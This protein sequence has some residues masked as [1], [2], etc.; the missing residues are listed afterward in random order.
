MNFAAAVKKKAN[1]CADLLQC[2]F[3]KTQSKKP[4]LGLF[5]PIALL[6]VNIGINFMAGGFCANALPILALITLFL[7][8]RFKR[9]GLIGSY[10]LLAIFLFCSFS[11]IPQNERIFQVGFF[12]S[13]ALTLFIFLLTNEGLQ[14]G[15]E[16]IEEELVRKREDFEKLQ[17]AFAS[18]QK[19]QEEKEREFEEELNRLKEQ[20]EQRKIDQI[21]TLKKNQLIQ[22]EIELLTSQ[23]EAFIQDARD[24]R[25][26]AF[27]ANKQLEEL[28]KSQL[29]QGLNSQ[30]KNI[31]ID[32]LMA[33]N[34]MLIN[35]KEQY[36]EKVDALS[37]KIAE[38]QKQFEQE[39]LYF[40]QQV[41]ASQQAILSLQALSQ[42]A[43]CETKSFVSDKKK[44]Q[45]L[46][47]QKNCEI[48]DYKNSLKAFEQSLA[49]AEG[50]NH[51][52]RLQF[53]EK[54]T[55]LSETRKHLFKLEGLLYLQK[56]ECEWLES[57][58]SRE[59]TLVLAHKLDEMIAEISILE[60]TVIS[61]EE[62]ISHIL[63]Q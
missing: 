43:I 59:E 42:K 28:E 45:L 1:R 20:A 50:L 15:L 14:D 58:G 6:L 46:M 63:S 40:K 49:H 33:Q 56:K 17:A 10:L 27:E 8:L 25:R 34:Q 30:Q 2:Y 29:D 13:L 23:K 55:I 38:Y 7:S 39:S 51:Q 18:F 22:R 21:A 62:L 54:T 61:M 47:E 48:E 35:E 60:E 32:G 16:E 41:E 37:I 5:V 12:F 36:A 24:A 57:D 52:L 4:S 11:Q 53:I 26:A 44:H 19:S 31:E 3:P 9:F